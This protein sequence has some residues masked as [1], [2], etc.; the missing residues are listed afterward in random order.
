[1][2]TTSLRIF[3]SSPGDVG[4]E[5]RRA[6][7]VIARLKKEFVRFFDIVPIL[8]EYEPM[9]ASGHFQDII[10]RPSTT[11]IVVMILW[12]RLGTP[13]PED[14][15]QGLDGRVPVTGTE[16]EFED[17]LR[18]KLEQGVPDLLVYRKSGEA[19]AR[20]RSAAELDLMRQ[21]WEALHAFWERHFVTSEGHF[22][23][24]FNTFDHADAFEAQLEEHLRHL[25]KTRLPKAGFGLSGEGGDIT[26]YDGSPFLGLNSFE[27]RHAAL[28]FGREQA[29]R[30]VLDQLAR[31][32][33]GGT[34]FLLLL[35]ASGSGK[36][37]LI[38]AGVVP[39]LRFPGVV[40]GV[41]WWRQAFF[42]PGMAGGRLWSALAQALLQPGALPEL[43]AGGTAAELE[44]QWQAAPAVC[45]NGVRMA[46]SHAR[47]RQTG[48]TANT[49]GCLVLVV[50]QLEE[51]FTLAV[52]TAEERNRFVELLAVL[53]GSGSVWVVAAMRSDY[54]HRTAE[55]LRLR[56]LAA[57]EGQYHLLPPRPAELEQMI[58]RPAAAAGLRFELDD[59]SGLGLDAMLHEAAAREPG[60]LPL[61]EFT[62]DELYRLDVLQQGGELLTLAS[63]RSLGG[64]DGAIAQRAESICSSMGV[65][66]PAVL[67]ALVT[68]QAQ[69]K[70]GTARMAQ[71]AEVAST[72]ER[73]QVLEQLVQG[74]LVVTG[75][76]DQVATARL[77]HEAL[78]TRW[79]RLAQLIVAD[80]SFLEVRSRLESDSAAWREK[81]RHPELLLPGGKR[82]AE[83]EE[84]LQ[85]RR[86]EL[87]PEVMDYVESSIR[88]D[89]HNRER[90]LRRARWVAVG[91]SGLAVAASW[92]GWLSHQQELRADKSRA[93]AEDLVDFVIFDL[94]DRLEPLGRLDFLDQAARKA[95]GYYGQLGDPSQMEPDQQVRMAAALINLGNVLQAQGNLAEAMTA[96]R[97][98][99]E[100]F[101]KLVEMDPKN[102]LWQRNLAVSHER[103]GGIFQAQGDLS[104]A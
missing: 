99:T 33:E 50:D 25:I 87:A 97:N 38:R 63:Y 54:F 41:G 40:S 84:V 15:Y 5:R 69:E 68:I 60:S 4:D 90:R 26:W 46:L 55:T 14:R 65:V 56:D 93:Q 21:Q 8:W 2:P 62:L 49:A 31:R 83:A 64:L 20:Y 16:W 51:L 45:A 74:R 81:E 72:P 12:S 103:L 6:A 36:S 42:R 89:R 73:A 53:A 39:Q 61:L 58:R 24:A 47:E 82:L 23:A 76:D 18:A 67:R 17:A 92:F 44:A 100:V 102:M 85:Q 28:F 94:R 34:A 104:G 7:I 35:G 3:I 48:V 71:V 43:M 1:M 13:L 59:E 29:E 19:L 10:E 88:Q 98:A 86:D 27:G 75:G 95:L 11:D 96:C 30:E 70:S 37:S 32:A 91:M 22:K 80:R 77:A 101:G 52:I 78:L 66:L 9:L 57:G 79:P